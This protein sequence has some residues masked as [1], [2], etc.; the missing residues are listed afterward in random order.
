M[1]TVGISGVA[2]ILNDYAP[3]A[4]VFTAQGVVEGE[5]ALR[6]FFEGMA[7]LMKQLAPVIKIDRQDFVD[8]IGYII[9]SAGDAVPMA[10]DT[11]VVRDGK[12]VTQ[13]F[14]AYMPGA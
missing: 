7:P 1:A 12:I 5:A 11:F 13:T 4:R 2:E 3:G 14:T 6:G 10:T 9:W 8:D